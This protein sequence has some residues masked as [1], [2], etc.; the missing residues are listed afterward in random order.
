MTFSQFRDLDL[1]ILLLFYNCPHVDFLY[2]WPMF[3]DRSDLLSIALFLVGFLI[4]IPTFTYAYFARDL[5]SK[6]MIM[7]RGNTGV[8]L[9]D[10]KGRPFFRLFQAKDKIYIPL[11]Q[12]PKTTQ[13][14]LI[15]T[16]DKDFYLHPGFSLK[17]I[18]RSAIENIKKR[19]LLYGG[20]TITQQLV[21]NSLLTPQ[22][23]FLRKYQELVLAYEIERRFKKDEI[24]EMYLNSVYFGEGAFGIEEAAQTY[25]GKSAKNLNLAES[26][27]LIS[28]L[29]SPSARN[30][31]NSNLEQQKINQLIIL[32]KMVEQKYITSKKRDEAIN[33]K[34]LFYSTPEPINIQAVH[35]A[36]MVQDQLIKQYGEERISRSGFKV[37][38]TINLD[39]Q[40]FAQGVVSGHVK[41]LAGSSVSNGAAVVIDSRTGGIKAMVGSIDWYDTSFGKVNVAT[42]LRQPGSSF[43]P[44]YYSKAIDKH[45]ITAS[46][47]LHDSPI[48]YKTPGT[49]VYS[50]KNYDGRFRGNVTVRRA[51]SNSL[52]VPS[53]EV[54]SKVGVVEALQTA[55]DFGITT[56]DNSN[57]RFGLS[58]A[59]GAGEVKL[60]ELTN[61]YA[62]LSNQ[63]L[64]NTPTAILEITDKNGKTIYKYQPKPTPVVSPEAAFIISSILSDNNT[65]REVFGDSLTMPIPA[66]IK[67]GTTENF[68]DSLTLSYTPYLAV[69][70]W[71]G[72][73]DGRAMDNVAGSLGAAPIAKDL[74][75]KFS[76]ELPKSDFMQP[77][78]V[79]RIKPCPTLPSFEYFIKGTNSSGYCPPKDAKLSPTP[80]Q[81]TT[82]TQSSTP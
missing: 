48:T 79:I 70:A 29:P 9:E 26:A 38:T 72:N 7:N 51:L 19:D 18:I 28:V 46:T 16:E 33:Q 27:L 52:N 3:I 74:I 8:I 75:L 37:K 58:L 17:S 53:V 66:A 39:W 60:L 34:L 76:E 77:D 68:R 47:I 63:G 10:D 57:S 36:L 1:T 2:Y 62:T 81:T 56:L 23:N 20:S 31:F 80:T 15:A 25:F 82:S 44:I 59:L 21:K 55:Q 43:K 69:G 13:E 32:D 54:M 42:S 11:S 67:T 4:T 65:R 30:P 50:P 12:I 78:G 14:A 64:K 40:Q 35:F 61:A 49:E 22:K 41:K 71:V 6:E 24:L 5:T 45:I 73:N